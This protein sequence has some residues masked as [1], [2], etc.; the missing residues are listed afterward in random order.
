MSK[1]KRGDNVLVFLLGAT[2]K[3][4]VVSATERTTTVELQEVFPGH[5][6]ARKNS[7]IVKLKEQSNNEE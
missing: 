5:I 6:T 1:F 4:K 3:A 7:K 2:V